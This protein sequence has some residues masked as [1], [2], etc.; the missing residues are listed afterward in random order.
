VIAE[1]GKDGG[2]SRPELTDPFLDSAQW[3]QGPLHKV[4][5][6]VREVWVQLDRS[7]ELGL[8]ANPVRLEDTVVRNRLAEHGR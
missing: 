1:R 7:R 8:D 3:N 4:F 5:V 6:N 2:V